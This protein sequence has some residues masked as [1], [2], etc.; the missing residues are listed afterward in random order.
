VYSTIP[1][2][3]DALFPP[4]TTATNHQY[5]SLASLNLRSSLNTDKDTVIMPPTDT[6]TLE[7]DHAFEAFKMDIQ[8]KENEK[9]AKDG[10]N[11]VRR[12][13]DKLQKQ[14]KLRQQLK[15]TQRY[16]GLVSSS[17]ADVPSKVTKDAPILFVCVDIEAFEFNQKLITE[18]GIST[19][20][21]AAI[22]NREPGPAGKEWATLI[23]SRHLRIIEHQKYTNKVHVENNAEN[24]T[25][26]KTEWINLS[27]V[28]PTLEAAFNPGE[29]A[30][31]RSHFPGNRQSKT[32]FVAHN[33]GGEFKY[34]TELGFN[35]NK[36]VDD[37][38]DS[39]D[40]FQVAR[41]DTRQS[42]L[43]KILL[44][45]GI[46]AP[47]LHNAGNDARYT[48]HG[49]I[50]I[51]VDHAT[52]KKTASDWET[53]RDKRLAIAYKEAEERVQA[54]MEGWSSGDDESDGDGPTDVANAV[55]LVQDRIKVSSGKGNGGVN[56]R[57]GIRGRGRGRGRGMASET[58]VPAAPTFVPSER[59]LPNHFFAG[60]APVPQ[61]RYAQ[62]PIYR[63]GAPYGDYDSEFPSLRR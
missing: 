18:I 17:N 31:T 6:P 4:I 3:L 51:A 49:M 15:R 5:V 14:K 1:S 43:F 55:K 2:H 10:I 25:F 56:V 62:G 8:A 26:G 21:T 28:I 30:S 23:N 19:L 27:N 36:H 52:N 11:G 38:I 42:A 40:I 24:F 48:L 57:G 12:K 47:Y 34:L 13:S 61:A 16:L 63:G 53:E 22:V 35:I 59:Y 37:C 20:S 58:V 41:R 50:A 32:V 44:G 60:G 9:Q 45:Y 39:S 33:K 7:V 54:E 46:A 29:A